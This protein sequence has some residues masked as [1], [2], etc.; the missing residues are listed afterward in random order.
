VQLA[1]ELAHERKR[2]LEG[3]SLREATL[4]HYCASTHM[5]VITPGSSAGEMLHVLSALER[6]SAR[7]DTDRESARSALSAAISLLLRLVGREHDPTKSKEHVLLSL[8]AERRLE[9]HQPSDLASLLEDLAHPPLTH[10]GPLELNAFISK[11]ARKDLA[12]AIN[13]LLVSPTFA[14]WREGTTL[15]VGA[16]LTPQHGRTPCVIVSVAHLDDDERALVLGM[17]LEEVLSWVRS[18]RGSQRLRALV[19]FDEVYGFLPPHPA[20]PPTKRPLVALMKQAR[21]F[22]VGVVVATQNPMDLDYR[23]L[24]NAGLWCVGR[25]QTDADRERVVEGLASAGAAGAQSKAELEDVLKRLAPRWFMTRDAHA[26]RNVALLQPRHAMTFMRG[27]M[28]R[29]EIRA[30]V[31]GRA[32]GLAAGGYTNPSLA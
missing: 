11:K 22:G 28:T 25:L 30:A 4:A 5:R 31:E 29:A 3:W 21:A 15:D 1:T 17:L 24:S 2:H 14:S 9:T 32:R 12:A 27:P 16:W 18:L 13:T 19:V 23:A 20:N 10:V 26:G 7:W 6:R 8:L